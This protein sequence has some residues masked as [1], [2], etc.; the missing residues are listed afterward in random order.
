M[1]DANI[2]TAALIALQ[3][4]DVLTTIYA[5]KLG[6]V[7]SNKVLAWLFNKT[8]NPFAALICVK[9]AFIALIAVQP[10]PVEILLALVALY[11]FVVG[12]NVV[13]IRGV[14]SKS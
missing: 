13:V 12:N 11:V 6:C 10:L 2:L 1:T 14:K 9:A 7:E 8:G 5:F 3:A 4:L